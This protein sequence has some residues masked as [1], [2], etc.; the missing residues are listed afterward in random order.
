MKIRIYQIVPERDLDHI[1]FRSSKWLFEHEGYH[2]LDTSIY[3]KVFEGEVKA[4]NLEDVFC[5]FNSDNRPGKNT[6]RS[7][8]VS[9]VIAVDSS[10]TPITPGYYYCDVFGFTPVNFDIEAVSG[11]ASQ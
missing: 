2:I 1:M 6:F 8:S 10:N 3:D 11:D 5:L 7:L 4:N 9:D